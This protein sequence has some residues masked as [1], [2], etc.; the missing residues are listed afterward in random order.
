MEPDSYG[1][2]LLPWIDQLGGGVQ[3]V[4]GKRIARLN[5]K[6]EREILICD[7]CGADLPCSLKLYHF[8]S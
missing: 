7:I 3:C 2:W 8:L 1:H 5:L 4:M 6:W